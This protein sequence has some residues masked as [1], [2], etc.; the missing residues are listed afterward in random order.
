LT[1]IVELTIDEIDPHQ[2]LVQHPLPSQRPVGVIQELYGLLLAHYAVR[3]IMTDAAAQAE[4]APVHKTRDQ[5]LPLDDAVS[6]SRSVPC[7]I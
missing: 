1:S 3:A 5:P 7:L 2:R 4:I 6:T